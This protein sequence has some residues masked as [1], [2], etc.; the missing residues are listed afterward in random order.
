MSGAVRS[1]GATVQRAKPHPAECCPPLTAKQV[2]PPLTSSHASL[3]NALPLFPTFLHRRADLMIAPIATCPA[4]NALSWLVSY[5]SQ[6]CFAAQK[7][8]QL[9]KRVLT[10]TGAVPLSPVAP[11][12]LRLL[13]ASARPC[14]QQ[15]RGCPPKPAEP[16]THHKNLQLSKHSPSPSRRV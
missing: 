10:I 7:V 13:A 6:C 4:S 2:L 1:Y 8:S 12:L 3:C 15:V 5:L 9:L 11:R 14:L 16:S